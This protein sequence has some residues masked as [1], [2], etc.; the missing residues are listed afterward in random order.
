MRYFVNYGV[1]HGAAPSRVLALVCRRGNIEGVAVGAIDVR[2][3][4]TTFDVRSEVASEFEAAVQRPDPR[5]P[6][7]R[8]ER[9]RPIDGRAARPGPRP[10][11][12]GERRAFTKYQAAPSGPRARPKAPSRPRRTA[13]S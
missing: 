2:D 7:I 4:G 8:I 11:T 3:N 10:R 1:R 5:D 9:F 6:K 12:P 13:R